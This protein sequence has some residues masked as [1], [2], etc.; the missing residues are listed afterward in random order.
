[1]SAV[2]RDVEIAPPSARDELVTVVRAGMGITAVVW[3]YL[4]NNPF[5]QAGTGLLQRSL[6]PFQRVVAALPPDQQ[7][8]FRELQVGLLEAETIRSVEAK[9]PEPDR[10]AADGI[11]PFAPNPAVKGSA[12]QWRLLRSGFV[13][14]YLGIP[15]DP[16]SH[17]WLL[18]VQEPDPAGPPDVFQDDQE[19]HRLVDGTILHIAIWNHPDG[20]R[21]P[22]AF[23]QVPQNGGW[24]QL[25]AA[26]PSQTTPEQRR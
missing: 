25:Y 23:V 18:T 26:E 22:A 9:W 20:G 6:L 16:A 17:A 4:A 10:L 5:P 24:L 3:L 8:I 19:H 13:V 21:V 7:R 11:E 1:V 15:V 2:S 14:N 12:Y